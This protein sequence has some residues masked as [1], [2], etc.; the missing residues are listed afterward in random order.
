MLE[1]LWVHAPDEART[2]PARR[3]G[4]LERWAGRG[5]GACPFGIALRPAPGARPPLPFAGWTYAPSYLPAG[6]GIHVAETSTE[7][8]E[9]FL[10][11]LPFADPPAHLAVGGAPR[12]RAGV[13]R[14]TAVRLETPVDVASGMRA[15][16]ARTAGLAI[17][18]GTTHRLTLGF[19][20][21]GLGQTPDLRPDLPLVLRW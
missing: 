2:G 11:Y 1:C 5:D 7:P 12:H 20:G 9:P 15:A 8:T 6:W 17:E 19:D 14:L 21:E 3:T 16:A 4:L 10:F 18:R 13:R